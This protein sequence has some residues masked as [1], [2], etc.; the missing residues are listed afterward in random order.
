M[1][2]LTKAVFIALLGVGAWFT[3]GG[4][5]PKPIPHLDPEAWWGPKDLQGKLDKSIRPFKVKF[6]EEMI[7]DLRYR[8]KNHRPFTPPLEGVAFEY[9]FNTNQIEGWLNYWA[10]KYNFTE[11]ETF[12]NQFPHYKTYIQGL[13]MHFIRVTPKVSKDVKVIPLLMLHGWG[14]S[15]R[16]FYEAIPLLTQQQTGYNFVFDLIV[17]S[18]PGFG[19]SQGSVR[20]G[21]GMPEAAVILKNLM[22]RLGYENFYV[23]GGDFGGAVAAVMATLYPDV[24]LGY[25]SNMLLSQHS[26]SIF[27]MFVGAYFPSLIVEPHLADRMY[28]L[29]K[30]FAYFI[31]ELGY[32]HLHGTKPDT[33]G[34]PLTDSPAG[35]LAYM[36]E[37]F[38]VWTRTEFKHLPDGGLGLRFTKDQL[39]DNLMVYW[40]TNSITTSIRFY[41]ENLNFEKWAM[42][43]D[44]IPTPVPTWALQAKHEMIYQPPALLTPKFTNL[45]G[46]TI[47]DDGGHFLAFELP[48]EFSA[49]VFNGFKKIREWRQKNGKIEL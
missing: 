15:V 28:P 17:P 33:I 20:P 32:M 2:F 21:L 45:V 30:F 44:D 4:S 41:A 12:F 11:R 46:T 35:F 8:L 22:N 36:L 3:F 29:S 5:S 23:Q 27:R 10:E 9:G 6:E 13:D 7:K 31:E 40:S 26:T 16:E 24:M 14:G 25:H 42:G 43:L 1:G 38:S 18:L 37:K 48:K 47:L 49:D 34:V 19:F 39:L